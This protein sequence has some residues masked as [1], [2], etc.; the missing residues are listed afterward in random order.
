MVTDGCTHVGSD[1]KAKFATKLDFF[2]EHGGE[3]VLN[4]YELHDSECIRRWF[5]RQAG[6]K[7]HVHCVLTA[8]VTLQHAAQKDGSRAVDFDLGRFLSGVST[9][10]LFSVF[11]LWMVGEYSKQG[12]DASLLSDTFA[13][14]TFV[15]GLITNSASAAM[16]SFHEIR[17]D[18]Q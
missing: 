16:C 7:R 1:L 12:F 13:C 10:L 3:I 6:Q 2:E 8:F 17:P 15:N 14:S 5:G 4:L 18:R 11:E 9:S